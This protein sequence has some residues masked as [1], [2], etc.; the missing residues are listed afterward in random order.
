VISREAAYVR[1]RPA[2]LL[3]LALCPGCMPSEASRSSEAEVQRT[4]SAAAVEHKVNQ[5]KSAFP[6][7]QIQLDETRTRV[8]RIQR[9]AVTTRANG[10]EDLVRSVLGN[11]AVGSV[12]GLS[13]DLHELCEPVS[14]KDSQLP[15]H[16]VVRMQQCVGGVKVLGAEL[17]M[18]VRLNPTQGIDTLTSSLVADVPANAT[19]KISAAAAA[20]TA[21]EAARELAGGSPLSTDTTAT[22]E[23]VVFAPTL[24]QLEGPSRLCWLV[25]VDSIAVL[26]DAITGAVVHHFSE[27]PRVS[28]AIHPA[29]ERVK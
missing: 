14:R 24:F 3:V 18:S 12:L 21:T 6:E 23:L 4:Q 29:L 17:V 28:A 26:I 20:K 19:P 8:A 1:R 10:A 27:A 16:A 25:R 15:G 9:L 11:R 5:L 22:T 13:N 7:A 2:V